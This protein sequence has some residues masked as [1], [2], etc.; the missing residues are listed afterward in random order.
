MYRLKAYL[1]NNNN[2]TS[3]MVVCAIKAKEEQEYCAQFCRFCLA[4]E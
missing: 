2:S 4:Q 1:E 3:G